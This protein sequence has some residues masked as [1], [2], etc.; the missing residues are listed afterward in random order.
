MNVVIR[1]L[2]I[3]VGVFIIG[4]IFWDGIRRNKKRKGSSKPYAIQDE[5]EANID[6][7]DIESEKAVE[8]ELTVETLD[9]IDDENV[10]IEE[11]IEVEEDLQMSAVDGTLVDEA[12]EALMDVD[13]PVEEVQAEEVVPADTKIV[14]DEEETVPEEDP[15]FVR[16]LAKKA[17]SFSG[18]E[19][20]QV[21]LKHNFHYGKDKMFHYY[22]A[23]KSSGDKYL[24]IAAATEDGTFDITKIRTM[25]CKSIILFL[26]PESPLAREEAEPEMQ[27][28]AQRLAKALHAEIVAG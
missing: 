20:L 7:A 2:I 19:L 1:W 18:Y 11:S 5:L 6:E 22:Q 21:I 8:P 16:I 17:R 10:T 27:M 13:E 15:L 23:G 28:L 24:S 12:E 25:N 26:N 3:V 14:A 9:A 4:A